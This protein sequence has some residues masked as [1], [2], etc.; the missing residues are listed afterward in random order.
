M[1]ITTMIQKTKRYKPQQWPKIKKRS[2]QRS[3][4]QPHIFS[5][6][7]AASTKKRESTILNSPPKEEDMKDREG[8]KGT[9]KRKN[10]SYLPQMMIPEGAHH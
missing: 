8:R 10:T 9:P 5:P 4:P 2:K 7:L 1:F 3:Y 6:F